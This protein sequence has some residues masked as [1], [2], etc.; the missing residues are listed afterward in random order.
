MQAAIQGE[1]LQ[2][3]T[4]RVM[5]REATK[6]R[7][8]LADAIP[9]SV[10]NRL[11]TP[12]E[13]LAR[14]AAV[15]LGTAPPAP[16]AELAPAHVAAY[17]VAVKNFLPQHPF[18][19]GTGQRPS[20]AVF[21]AAITA[22]AL[23]SESADTVA[24]AEQRVGHGPNTPNP[25]LLDF[26]LDTAK[27]RQ[28]DNPVVPPEHVIALYQSVQARTGP[29]AIIRMSIEADDEHEDADV[30]IQVA[31]PGTQRP[32]C[33]Q[34]RTSQAGAL[35][36][37]R[38]VNGVSVDAPLLDVTIGSGNPVEIIA[39]VS[40]NVGTLALNCPELV[41]SRGDLATES[42]DSLVTLEARE[43]VASG[44]F[45]APLVRSGATLSVSWPGAASYPWSQF[46]T[47]AKG[48]NGDDLND[49]L[50]GCGG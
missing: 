16:P 28:G 2:Q 30:E 26:Y 33:L 36:F 21:A 41:V 50:R 32:D 44:I 15:V 37:G 34:L 35:R 45:N 11:Y 47:D 43:L 8:Q 13:Q 17:N 5:D 12:R 20:G 19:D 6:L 10:S 4:D 39:P 31:R 25:F 9:A 22:N 23:F 27:R 7:A 42:D 24:M 38:Q 14:L 49:A 18:L 46:A 29:G 48:A 3:L 40:M 1:V